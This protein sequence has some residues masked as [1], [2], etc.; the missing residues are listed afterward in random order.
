MTIR[1]R[2][3]VQARD[4]DVGL[5]A[6]AAVQHLRVDDAAERPVDVVRAD[7]P[8]ECRC[9]RAGHLE[10]REARLVEQPCR[11]SGREVFGRD[12]GRPV[13]P[14][15][16][17]RSQVLETLVLV[18]GEPVRP[19]PPRLLAELGAERLQPRVRGGCLQRP[20]R[21]RLLSWVPDVVVRR[22]DL[23]RLGERVVA[24]TVRGAE[25][26]DVHLRQV[27]RGLAL[28]DPLGGGAAHPRGSGDAV[29]A[30]PRGHEQ[31]RDLGLAEDEVVV[32]REGLGAVDE[33]V[34]LHGLQR[35]DQRERALGDR[36]EPRP[37]L[38]QQAVV[39]VLRDRRVDVPGIRVPLVAADDQTAHLLSH[40]DEAVGVA[41]RREVG[42]DTLDRAGDQI[43]VL[44][45]DDG[46]LHTGHAPELV[47]PQ[48]SRDHHHL[49]LDA[50]V[51]G[52]GAGH[53]AAF[54][55]DL[56]DP[57][58]GTDPCAARPG[59][60]GEGRRETRGVQ[61]PVRRDERGAQHVRAVDQREAVVRLRRRDDLDRQAER[62]GPS[63]HARERLEPVG[64]GRE[65]QGS[66]LVP[67]WVDAGLLVQAGIQVDAVHHHPR[68]ADRVPQL[69][70]QACRMERRAARE[71]GALNEHDVGPAELREVVGDAGTG[72]ASADDNDARAILGH[73]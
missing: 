50:T 6:A 30:E 44:H 66:H 72:D 21:L 59:A 70:D 73:G 31:A 71:L 69:R 22:V 65:V 35:R 7:P 45:R 5:D 14:R 9:S 51:V 46:D 53:A 42:P 19:F 55:R 60:F 67:A 54:D 26:P 39:E 41:E 1:Y 12:R 63:G 58:A 37:L 28:D 43:L 18:G 48:A 23:V 64:R 4:R 36:L 15:P 40:V 52:D 20:T 8:Q 10:L 11:L 16:S 62:L 47:G 34:D 49:G 56:H 25:P 61:V 3:S 2:S 33:A 38:L 27:H 24:V 17:S 32:G 13:L 57:D 29:C 68:V